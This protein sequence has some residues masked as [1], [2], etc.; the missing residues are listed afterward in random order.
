MDG[1]ADRECALMFL[2]VDHVQCN[3]VMQFFF[4]FP[5]VR[6]CLFAYL[7]G[8]PS[9]YTNEVTFPSPASISLSIFPETWPKK[10]GVGKPCLASAY[11]NYVTVPFLQLC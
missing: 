6:V 1:R 8:V 10:R 2:E 4:L 9:A 5:C 7:H 3:S 11:K